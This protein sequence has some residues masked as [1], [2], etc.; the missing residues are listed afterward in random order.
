MSGN[1]INS[2]DEESDEEEVNEQPAKPSY[3]DVTNAM[4]IRRL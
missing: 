2:S 3:A 1:S 4:D